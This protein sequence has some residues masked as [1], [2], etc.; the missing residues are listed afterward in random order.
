[1]KKLHNI[2]HIVSVKIY[3]KKEEDFYKY[4][5]KRN[6]LFW[7]NRKAGWYSNDYGFIY[8]SYIPTTKQEVERNYI[9]EDNICYTKPYVWIEFSNKDFKKIIFNT[10]KECE[11]YIEK[12]SIKLNNISNLDILIELNK[13]K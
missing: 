11:D 8:E 12:L 3:D 9:I 2:Q 7:K 5:L 6:Y 13:N 1:M 10:L 4:F